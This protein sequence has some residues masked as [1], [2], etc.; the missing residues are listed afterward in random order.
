MQCLLSSFFQS[1][2]YDGKTGDLRGELGSPAHKGGIYAVS[3]NHMKR[4]PDN[5]ALLSNRL[6]I[7]CDF[8]KLPFRFN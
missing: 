1:F 8:E 5:I 7:C 6:V 3:A 2:L 4:F